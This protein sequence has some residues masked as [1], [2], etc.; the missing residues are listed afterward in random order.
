[1]G[2]GKQENRGQTE[3]FLIF[4]AAD[5]S[6]SSCRAIDVPHHITQRGNARQ[7]ILASDAEIKPWR[8]YM[9]RD[10]S[11]TRKSPRA[12]WLVC[13][14]SMLMLAASA[15]APSVNAGAKAET[16]TYC[17]VL[18]APNAFDGKLIR[19]TGV[20]KYS[21]EV[22]RLF[23]STCCEDLDSKMWVEFG[24]LDAKSRKRVHH[25]PEGTG[26]VLGTFVGTLGHSPNSQGAQFT[27]TVTTVENVERVTKEIEKATWAPPLCKQ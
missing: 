15:L 8:E 16:V 1:M 14:L 6:F 11:N 26:M 20:Y 25:F 27:L 10:S 12:C 9:K 24:E 18:K 22:Q 23:P 4:L 19:I 21:F 13:V 5:G 17:Q 2:N 3:R 7:F